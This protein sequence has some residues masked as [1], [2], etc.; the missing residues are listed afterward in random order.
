MQAVRLTGWQ[1]PPELCEVPDPIPG[2]GAVLLRVAGAGLCHSDLHL[3]HWAAGTLPYDLPFTLGHEVAGRVVALGPGRPAS[4]S[5]TPSSS[6]GRGAAASAGVAASAR[7]T[8]ASARPGRAAAG[9]ATTAD[10]RSTSSSPR[11]G[12]WCRSATSTP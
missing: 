3:M 1:S 4:T 12:C 10:W 11:R 6:T 2:P 8:S 7:S 5:A 9:W